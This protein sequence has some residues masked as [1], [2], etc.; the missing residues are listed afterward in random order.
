MI[1]N[2]IL[3][4]TDSKIKVSVFDSTGFPHLNDTRKNTTGIGKG[5][6]IIF[7]NHDGIWNTY[8]HKYRQYN[9]CL[10]FGRL[11]NINKTR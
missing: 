1:V 11:K 9:G 10:D 2:E 8:Q 5:N 3:N 7:K 6:I 4:Q